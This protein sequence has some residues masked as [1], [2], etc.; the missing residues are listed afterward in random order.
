[1]TA[2]RWGILSA[3]AISHDFVV[4]LKTL[5][6]S[7]HKVVAV[8]A[9]SLESAQKFAAKHGIPR[10]YGSYA[11]LESDAEVDVVYVGSIHTTHLAVASKVLEARKPVLCEKPMTMCLRDTRALV[12]QARERG[13]F[14]MEAVWMRYF[15]AVCELRKMI[16]DGAIGEVKYLRAN[17][18]FRMPP[19]RASGRLVDPALGGGG[20]LDLGVYPINLATMIFN[21]RPTKIHAQG[22]LLKTGVD[23]LAAITLTYSGGRIAQL[24]SSLSY[25]I[26][27]DA[28]I[29]GTKGELMLPHPF[30]C[31]TKLV[32]PQ[33]VYNKAPL[34]LEFPLPEPCLPTNYPN[35]TGLRYEA[36]E[37]RR[38]ILA[39]E[40]ESS[41][42]PLEHS[43]IVAEVA[44]EV[45][46]QIGVVYCK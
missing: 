9:R 5:P 15:P 44:D 46:R 8:A 42:M 4:A 11:E 39:G 26:T 33:G 1:M 19:D 14:F 41:V 22:T 34:N 12:E 37:V 23:D 31:S 32:K 27:C 17:F 24:T 7:E 3:G 43:L 21:E 28:V 40:K 35:S 13:V 36:E 25:D 18:S 16:A 2:I 30:W 6:E 10:A 20:V 45:M 38:C 29:C